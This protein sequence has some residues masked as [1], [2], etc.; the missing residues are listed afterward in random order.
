[1]QYRWL[2]DLAAAQ[3]I[4]LRQRWADAV[5]RSAAA[6]DEDLATFYAARFGVGRTSA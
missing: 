2:S 1:L 4:E 3:R 6:I 5:A